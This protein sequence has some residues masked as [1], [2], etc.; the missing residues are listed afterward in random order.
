MSIETSQ[1]ETVSAKP[2]ESPISQSE[3]LLGS[4]QKNMGVL[5]G[6]RAKIADILFALPED[7][8]KGFADEVAKL[9][10][11]IAALPAAVAD[12]QDRLALQKDEQN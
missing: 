4:A 2:V 1:Q 3:K 11:Q 5:M 8:R 6:E 9:E 7:L 10:R 12:F